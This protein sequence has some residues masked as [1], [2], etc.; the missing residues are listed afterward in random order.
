VGEDD[1]EEEEDDGEGDGDGD[2]DLLGDGEGDADLLGDADGEADLLGDCD[3][4]CDGDAAAE[5]TD[6][7]GGPDDAADGV[8]NADE[9]APCKTNG[10]TGSDR[11]LGDEPERPGEEP[12]DTDGDEIEAIGA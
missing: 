11:A 5:D 3:C 7:I 9:D 10:V 12:E 1:G 6:A 4:D 8:R 2:A